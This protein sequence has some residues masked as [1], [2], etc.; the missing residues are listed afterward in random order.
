ML[1]LDLTKPWDDKNPREIMRLGNYGQ[2]RS[3][4]ITAVPELQQIYVGTY[5][6]TSI[7]GGALAVYNLKEDNYKIY[8][9]YIYNQS[10][11]SFLHHNRYIYGGTSVHAN[12][13]VNDR[14]ARFFRFNPNDPE[15]KEYIH[16]PFKSSMITSLISDERGRI[17]G[18]GDGT[19]FSY[20]PHTKEI[21]S[22][23]ILELISGRFKNAKII[24]GIDRNIYGTVEGKLFKANPGTL[25]IEILLEEGAQEIAQDDQGNLYYRDQ[26]DLWKYELPKLQ[27]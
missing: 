19:L 4:A 27:P 12:Y 1:E 25:E 10:L 22:K 18:M 13:K 7:G 11:I 23:E 6:E 24:E 8:E 15:E 21:R 17:W 9:N 2:S 16:L 3:T 20:D 14:G 5:P 26:A